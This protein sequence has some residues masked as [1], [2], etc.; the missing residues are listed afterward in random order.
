MGEYEP[1]DSRVVTQNPSATPG[2]PERTGPREGASRQQEAPSASEAPKEADKKIDADTEER[3]Q[4]TRDERR[5]GET[6]RDGE[7]E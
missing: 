7:G 4:V 2:E 6:S 5:F 1:R 3:W